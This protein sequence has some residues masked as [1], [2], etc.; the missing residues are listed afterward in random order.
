M[1]TR[2]PAHGESPALIDAHKSAKKAQESL[3]YW[4]KHFACGDS[5]PGVLG[6]VKLNIRIA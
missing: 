3:E 4:P 2:N 5:A 1:A 6:L